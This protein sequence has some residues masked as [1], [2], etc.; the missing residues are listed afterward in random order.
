MHVQDV[1]TSTTLKFPSPESVAEHLRTTTQAVLATSIVGLDFL[2]A[3]DVAGEDTEFKRLD[4]TPFL[5]LVIGE[6]GKSTDEVDS[7]RVCCSV[8]GVAVRKLF[9]DQLSALTA[10]VEWDASSGCGEAGKK[11]MCFSDVDGDQW[12]ELQ[13]QDCG[14]EKLSTVAGFILASASLSRRHFPLENCTRYKISAKEVTFMKFESI[15]KALSE[16]DLWATFQ[17][18]DNIDWDKLDENKSSTSSSCTL[19]S[20]SAGHSPAHIPDGCQTASEEVLSA[21]KEG[22]SENKSS[23]SSSCTLSSMSAGHSPAHIPD[24]SQT[25]SEEVLSAHKEGS[26]TEFIP[27][28]GSTTGGKT[29]RKYSA[30]SSWQ[31]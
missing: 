27:S 8:N 3:C 16:D 4:G 17:G 20:M 19:S 24:G 21:H 12:I 22:S 18:D 14:E 5:F 6:A 10:V 13:Y 28:L 26:S 2:P 11:E 9:R 1:L 15:V 25:A 31:E 7:L 23:T 30:S 29:K